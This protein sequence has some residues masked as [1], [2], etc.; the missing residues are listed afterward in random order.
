MSKQT[1]T[2]D[3]PVA[4]ADLVA[5]AHRADAAAREAWAAVREAER[6]NAQLQAERV[7][8]AWQQWADGYDPDKLRRAVVDAR[9]AL[10]RTAVAGDP[11]GPA[12]T[13]YAAAMLRERAHHELARAAQAAG[14]RLPAPIPPGDEGSCL[15][16][17]TGRVLRAYQPTQCGLLADHIG[18]DALSQAAIAE[19]E[20]QVAEETAAVRAQ[21][22][23]ARQSVERAEPTG[24]EVTIVGAR[25][26]NTFDHYGV[27]FVHGVARVPVDHPKLP[28]FRRHPDAYKVEPLY[29]GYPAGDYGAG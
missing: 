13:A 21:V 11:P 17:H 19:A 15:R 9:A 14:T 28:H 18:T 25:A 6:H 4:L 2:T 27:R 24:Y 5:A 22:E 8:A 10:D 26:G 20:R 7:R 16:D 23:A 1:T 29:A 3:Q 12:I